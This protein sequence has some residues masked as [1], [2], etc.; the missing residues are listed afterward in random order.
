MVHGTTGL[1]DDGAWVTVYCFFGHTTGSVYAYTA[2]LRSVV[3]FVVLSLSFVFSVQS[4]FVACLISLIIHS[5][6]S[7]IPISRFVLDGS[8]LTPPHL[9]N[10]NTSLPPPQTR[11]ASSFDN[12]SSRIGP[13]CFLDTPLS[14]SCCVP[15]PTSWI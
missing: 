14:H 6:F 2:N 7:I 8:L 12:V 3:Y 9:L 1:R 15:V 13:C 11:H 4:N 5:H 10:H